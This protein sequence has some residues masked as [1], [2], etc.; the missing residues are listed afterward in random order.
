MDAKHFTIYTDGASKGN[1]GPAAIGAVI[2]DES[3]K[4][5][6][7]VSRGIGRATNNQTEYLALI[8]GLEEAARLGVEHI[9]VRSD[10][11]LMVRQI[12]GEY[13]VRNTALKPLFEKAQHLM[14]RFQYSRIVHIP[15]EQNRSADA[16]CHKALRK[17]R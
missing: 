16:L 8:A 4:V 10:S 15:R 11:E 1:P 9:E 6:S 2:L 17:R 12:R 7:Q 5:V 3:G 14:A 13:R